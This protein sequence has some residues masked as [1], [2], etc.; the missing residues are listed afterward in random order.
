M[1][2]HSNRVQYLLFFASNNRLGHVKMKEAMWEV[3]PQGDFR[4]SDATNPNQQ[5]LF[6][7]RDT[8]SLW[9]ALLENF[10]GQEATTDKIIEF[11]KDETA[12]LKKHMNAALVEHENP[13]LPAAERI[14][15]R[16]T[17]A[18]GS[19]RRKGSFPPSVLVTFPA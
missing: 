19:K 18:D 13:N 4:F 10:A 7:G 14:F 11:V 2:D 5:V 17:K 3:D 9:R 8:Q 1:R 6:D 15:V 12:F 16:D